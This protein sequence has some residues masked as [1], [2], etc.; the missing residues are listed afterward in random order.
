MSGISHW[1]WVLKTT[2]LVSQIGQYL[3]MKKEGIVVSIIWQPPKK[4]G[5]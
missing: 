4:D 2:L 3:E 1:A 5:S